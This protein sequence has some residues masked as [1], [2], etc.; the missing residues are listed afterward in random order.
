MLIIAVSAADHVIAQPTPAQVRPGEEMAVM[1][2]GGARPGMMHGNPAQ[3]PM[4]GMHHQGGGQHPMDMMGP[5]TPAM[6]LHHK[7][8]LALTSAQVTRLEALQKEAEP[9][10]VRHMQL[11]MSGHRAANQLLT[12]TTPDFAAFSKTLKEAVEHMVDG[13]VVMARAAVASRALLTAA[14]RQKLEQL[15]REMHKQ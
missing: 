2:C 15:M 11:A 10:C 13:H 3:H 4:P 12:P 5:P 1:H 6:L 14:Q 9:A 8:E 7:Q